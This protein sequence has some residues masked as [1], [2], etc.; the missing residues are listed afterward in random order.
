M[1]FLEKDIEQYLFNNPERVEFSMYKGANPDFIEEWIH[2]QLIVPSGVIDLL[3]VTSDGHIAIVELKKE[4]IDSKAISQ[5]CR[6]AHDIQRVVDGILGN[7]SMIEIKKVVIGK[8]ID[9]KAMFEATSMDVMCSIFKF[10]SGSLDIFPVTF[11][12]DYL[13]SINATLSELANDPRLRTT[14]QRLQD[15]QLKDAESSHNWFVENILNATEEE[16]K[17]REDWLSEY[18]LGETCQKSEAVHE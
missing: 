18:L 7:E 13:S 9:K 3:G 6:Y 11:T 4:S 1:K 17:E 12:W 5:V 10:N 14:V 15:S 2:R 16:R 8:S